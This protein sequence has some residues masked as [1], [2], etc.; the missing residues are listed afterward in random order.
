MFENFTRVKKIKFNLT[1]N[2][3]IKEFPDYKIDSNFLLTNA[4]YLRKRTAFL[5]KNYNRGVIENMQVNFKKATASPL[6]DESVVTA[7]INSYYHKDQTNA[8]LL[9]EN[10]NG[11]P[12]VIVGLANSEN[13]ILYR[14]NANIAIPR[15]QES[16]RD[17]T[18]ANVP[19]YKDAEKLVIK[20]TDS[21]QLLYSELTPWAK[22][23]TKTPYQELL[24]AKRQN[25][26]HC[27]LNRMIL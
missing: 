26:I 12:I 21:D 9:I 13:E 16:Y 25:L 1:L 22:N 24:Y 3:L 11:V 4:F 2:P 7:F 17:T 6:T 19:F 20:L 23:T 14:F 8:K 15:F 10:Y 5:E 27:S 18:I